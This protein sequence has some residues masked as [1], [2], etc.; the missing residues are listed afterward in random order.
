MT[1][2]SMDISSLFSSA[3]PSAS[4]DAL[5]LAQGAGAFEQV[6]GD[7]R[8]TRLD[9]KR[10]R[11][12]AEQLVGQALFMPLLKQARENPFKTELFHGGRGEEAFGAQ[13]DQLLADRL[14]SRDA[15]GL[16]QAISRRFSGGGA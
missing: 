14:A 3:G 16:V 8:E 5:G 15:S 7:A 9:E 10:A 2:V 6:L 11:A 4:H 13:M 1:P 12:A